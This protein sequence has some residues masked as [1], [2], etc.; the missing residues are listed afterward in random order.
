MST[1]F[2][3]KGCCGQRVHD[4]PTFIIEPYKIADSV[5]NSMTE[6][7]IVTYHPAA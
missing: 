1:F 7:A 5:R 3:K 6:I 4:T 2:V